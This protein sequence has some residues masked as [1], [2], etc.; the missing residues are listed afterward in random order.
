VVLESEMNAMDAFIHFLKGVLKVEKEFRWTPTQA[1]GHP[2]I[3]RETFT[4]SYEPKREQD[5]SSNHDTMGEDT[6]SERSSS[7]KDSKEYK[8]GSCPSKILYPQTASV[9]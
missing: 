8:A 1:M 9:P 3:T 5:K 2:F 7:S 6:M 4:G